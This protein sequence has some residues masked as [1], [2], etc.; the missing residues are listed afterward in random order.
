MKYN[1]LINELLEILDKNSDIVNLKELKKTLL[2]DSNFL[3]DL[4][5]FHLIKTVENKKI[6]Y[7]NDNYLK[8]LKCETNI[9]ILIQEI[10]NKFKI[11]KKNGCLR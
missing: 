5:K 7:Q 1:D 6:L 10:K 2:N 9:N 8:Y 3:R 4:E 11:F